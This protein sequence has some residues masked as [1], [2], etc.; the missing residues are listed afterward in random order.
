M[1]VRDAVV[2][3]CLVNNCVSLDQDRMPFV[4]INVKRMGQQSRGKFRMGGHIVRPIV[5]CNKEVMAANPRPLQRSL[6]HRRDF[7]RR[8]KTMGQAVEHDNIKPFVPAE[9]SSHIR[10][11]PFDLYVLKCLL[12]VSYCFRGAINRGYVRAT[13]SERRSVLPFATAQIENAYSA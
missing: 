11:K 13:S 4:L 7:P 8:G 10:N 12:T 6:D 1:K 3:M 2:R 9:I 5:E